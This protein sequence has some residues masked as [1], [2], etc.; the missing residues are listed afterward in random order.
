MHHRR[1]T[2][3]D[4]RTHLI[5]VDHVDFVLRGRPGAL[6]VVHLGDAQVLVVGRDH[7]G[8]LLHV[9]K[10]NPAPPQKK[11]HNIQTCYIIIP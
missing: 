11:K 2:A 6:V 3:T 8:Q 5:G 1:K 4:S 7:L 9:L 10:E